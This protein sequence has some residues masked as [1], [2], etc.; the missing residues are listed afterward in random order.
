MCVLEAKPAREFLEKE[1]PFL[2]KILQFAE[3]A[4]LIDII[5]IE[6]PSVDSVSPAFCLLWPPAFLQDRTGEPLLF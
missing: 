4:I 6:N 2:S 5:D 3:K 1:T